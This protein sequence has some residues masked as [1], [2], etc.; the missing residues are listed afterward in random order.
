MELQ[1]ALIQVNDLRARI[2]RGEKPSVEEIKAALAQIRKGQ[3]AR[4]SSTTTKKGKASAQSI[5][6]D[7]LFSET[8]SE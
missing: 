1:E 5:D 2:K 8:K 6:I 4:R 3:A 7:S